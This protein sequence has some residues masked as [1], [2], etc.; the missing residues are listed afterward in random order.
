MTTQITNLADAI[1]VILTQ[2]DSKQEYWF[3]GHSKTS[4]LLLPTVM[5][6]NADGY[7]YNE[8]KLLREFIRIHPEARK[9]HTSTAELLTY[10]QHYGL[11]TR[12]L[13]L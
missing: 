13:D 10:A 7:F 3:R 11:P 9:N 12:L 5:R 2:L 1:S 4:F 6:K 8:E